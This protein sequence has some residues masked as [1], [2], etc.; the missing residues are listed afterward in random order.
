MTM[1]KMITIMIYIIKLDFCIF[2]TGSSYCSL[3]FFPQ[4]SEKPTETYLHVPSYIEFII[5]LNIN[6]FNERSIIVTKQQFST[7]SYASFV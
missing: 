7:A 2:F 5:N 6:H 1:S 4:G 3:A